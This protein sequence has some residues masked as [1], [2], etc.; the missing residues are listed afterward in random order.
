MKRAEETQRSAS[1]NALTKLTWRTPT[2]TALDE[3]SIDSGTLPAL[4]G[5][6]IAT[7]AFDPLFGGS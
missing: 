1:Q 4:E 5:V 2:V 3:P 7:I 6:T